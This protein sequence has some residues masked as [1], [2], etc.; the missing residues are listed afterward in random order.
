MLLH[1]LHDNFCSGARNI[2]CNPPSS[3]PR[4][5]LPQLAGSY[6]RARSFLP[7]ISP[8][9]RPSY[10]DS[11]HFDALLPLQPEST[12]SATS[13]REGGTNRRVSLGEWSRFFRRASFLVQCQYSTCSLDRYTISDVYPKSH[14]DGT[15]AS[16]D[17]RTQ[18]A[19]AHTGLRSVPGPSG[20]DRPRLVL[21][22][23]VRNTGRIT[24][25]Y[26]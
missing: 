25:P 12:G 4:N 1:M 6:I 22:L 11:L 7:S 14:N 23:D 20:S 26:D 8:M 16:G 19:I 5:C 17:P 13:Q 18:H 2:Q 24:Y 3:R 15:L 21:Y 10:R 9:A